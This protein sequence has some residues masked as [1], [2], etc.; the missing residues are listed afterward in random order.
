AWHMRKLVQDAALARRIGE[1][2]RATIRR[3]F[4]YAAVGRRYR[5]RLEVIGSRMAWRR[6]AARAEA[7]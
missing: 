6:P 3:D 2:A 5:E 4:S 1:A 7:A